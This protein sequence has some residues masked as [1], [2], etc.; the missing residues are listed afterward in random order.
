MRLLKSCSRRVPWLLLVVASIATPKMLLFVDAQSSS[1]FTT[2]SASS[3][4]SLTTRSSPLHRRIG[5]LDGFGKSGIQELD[6]DDMSSLLSTVRPNAKAKH[7]LAAA[8]TIGVFGTLLSRPLWGQRDGYWTTVIIAYLLYFIE[9]MSSSTRRYLSNM[10]TPSQ[11]IQ[12]VNDIRESRPVLSWN[13]ES[14]HYRYE[15]AH[16]S[17]KGRRAQESRTKVVTHRASQNYV[18]NE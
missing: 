10:L 16:H 7:K 8:L 9:A 15:H 14:Y 3:I 5:Y 13:I 2:T 12:M 18:Y 1:S 6:G 17:G 11:V 4:Q